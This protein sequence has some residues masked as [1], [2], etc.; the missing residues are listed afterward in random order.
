MI[1]KEEMW[2]KINS[3]NL[4]AILSVVS[5]NVNNVNNMIYNSFNYMCFVKFY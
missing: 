2:D 4:F 5:E 1:I 3:A